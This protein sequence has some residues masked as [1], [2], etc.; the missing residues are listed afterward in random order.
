MSE[1]NCQICPLRELC[2][3]LTTD[4]E[5]FELN[6]GTESSQR[7]TVEQAIQGFNKIVDNDSSISRAV[8]IR[9]LRTLIEALKKELFEKDSEGLLH[10]K[11]VYDQE[12]Y[13][14]LLEMIR[15]KDILSTVT[16]KED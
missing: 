7:M 12:T 9:D 6:L 4:S 3:S 1:K 15:I 10:L 16:Q 5:K 2:S 13:T 11:K 14:Q 8:Y